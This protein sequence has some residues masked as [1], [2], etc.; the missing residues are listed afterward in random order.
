[1]TEPTIRIDKWLWY[2]RF[3]KSR[4]LSAKLVEA[5]RV[6]INGSKIRKSSAAIRVGD[7]LTFPQAKTI[8]V[9]RVEALGERRGP[10]AEAQQLYA[11]L[12][13]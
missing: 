11:E 13:A 3:F 6:R 12:K 5:G 9:V 7:V 10:A 8:L 2:A 4:S 1:M